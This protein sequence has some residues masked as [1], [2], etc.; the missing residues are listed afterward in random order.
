MRVYWFSTALGNLLDHHPQ[1]L[2][3]VERLEPGDHDRLV[4]A[5]G[6]EGIRA[7]ADD[8]A[9]MSRSQKAVEHQIRT[10][11]NRLDGRDD[12]DV[13]AEQRKIPDLFAPRL[14][15]RQCR[16]RH[17]GLKA[18][19]EEHDFAPW[20]VPG[21]LQ[22]IEGRVHRANVGAACLGLQQASLG[23]RHTH[24]VAEGGEN[25]LW[26]ARDREAVVDPPH[27]QDTDR[28]ARPV[29]EL[30]G[31]FRQQRFQAIAKDRMRVTTANFHDLQRPAAGGRERHGQACDG[32]R[33]RTRLAG[34][35]KFIGIAHG[36]H[37]Y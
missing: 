25:N 37:S 26:I 20:I 33:Q 22:R 6:N 34:I 5:L 7:V 27:R 24:R 4:V 28:A 30:D 3:Q 2:Q 36:S 19:C 9:D 8:H 14:Q 35:A 17:R 12:G 32:R 13:I 16:A 15:H 18:E 1:R 29:H 23:S 11:E 31:L 21:E 10:I